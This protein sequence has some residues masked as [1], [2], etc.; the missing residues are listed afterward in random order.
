M[1]FGKTSENLVDYSL[2][3]D[4]LPSGASRFLNKSQ[5]VKL[6]CFPFKRFFEHLPCEKVPGAIKVLGTVGE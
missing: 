5:F 1:V 3:A 2:Q 6:R 4:Q